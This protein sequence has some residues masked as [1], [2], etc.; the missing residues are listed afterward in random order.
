LF[1]FF[2]EKQQLLQMHGN[3]DYDDA[4]DYD[5]DAAGDDDDDEAAADDVRQ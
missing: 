2:E 5:A 3:Y 1:V 4:D